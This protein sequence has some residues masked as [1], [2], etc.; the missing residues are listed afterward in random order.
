MSRTQ[1][2]SC[3][4]LDYSIGKKRIFNDLSLSIYSG[5][6]V[7]ILGP[8][9]AGKS[10]LFKAITGELNITSG[11]VAINGKSRRDLSMAALAKCMAVLPQSANLSF[12][13]QVNEVV[14]MGGLQAICTQKQLQNMAD[15]IMREQGVLALK[16]QAYPTLSGGE[17]QR[18]HFCRILLQLAVGNQFSPQ[19]LLLDEPTAAL[20]INYQ[21]QLLMTAQQLALSGMAVVAVLHD[22]NLAAQYADRIILLNGGEICADGTP[23][24]V[25]T[26]DNIKRV[27]GYDSKKIIND[28][29]LSYPLV[30]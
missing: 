19:A 5:E 23:Q 4:N 15:N 26:T 14:L 30:I 8:N 28:G 10:S 1:V 2:I 22:L 29:E 6:L 17:K 25:L 3:R 11:A 16:Q 9:G 7:A 21:H 24:S 20:D 27:Y 18:V 13:F 12:A